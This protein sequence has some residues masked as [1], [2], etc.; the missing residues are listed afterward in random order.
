MN[1]IAK[2]RKKV[3]YCLASYPQSRVE[4]ISRRSRANL[5][6]VYGA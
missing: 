1:I 4:E 3:P 5:I 6:L 2:S